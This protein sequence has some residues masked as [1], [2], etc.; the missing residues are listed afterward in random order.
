MWD[1]ESDAGDVARATASSRRCDDARRHEPNRKAPVPK[2][3]GRSRIP[4]ASSRSIRPHDTQ[5]RDYHGHGWNF[6]AVFKRDRHER[7]PRQDDASSATMIRKSSRRPCTWRPLYEKGMQWWNYLLR[8]PTGNGY[9]D[10]EVRRGG[11]DRLREIAMGRCARIDVAHVGRSPATPAVQE[12]LAD[13][14]I[15]TDKNASN[16]AAASST[17]RSASIP[18]LE[19][20]VQ[21][22]KTRGSG[23]ARLQRAV[24]AR[25][26]VSRDTRRQNWV[27][28]PTTSWP[29]AMKNGML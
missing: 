13:C 2:G 11:R 1:Y 29:T 5:F 23:L 24:G 9:S 20:R 22:V 26:P 3:V 28:V 25:Q 6:R 10:G 8:T 7:C 16:G 4:N 14:R 12:P 19:W 15:P 27:H 21:A 18:A 17:Q